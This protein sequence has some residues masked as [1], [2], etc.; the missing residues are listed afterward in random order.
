MSKKS[1]PLP[2]QTQNIVTPPNSVYN[3]KEIPVV[4]PTTAG[5]FVQSGKSVKILNSKAL[6]KS[7]S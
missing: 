1:Y 7:K 2:N 4:V 6:P 5:V 3:S